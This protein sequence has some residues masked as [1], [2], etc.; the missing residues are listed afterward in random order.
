MTSFRSIPVAALA[1]SLL[2]SASGCTGYASTVRARA[3]SDFGCSESEITVDDI[4]G[5]TYRATGCGQTNE[6]TC[7]MGHGDVV[8][9]RDNAQTRGDAPS[10]AA[11]PAA[12]SSARPAATLGEPPS[13]A[14]GFTFGSGEDDARHACEQ[15]G[16]VYG[17]A[18][19]GSASCD[20]VASDIGSPARAGLTYC[21]GKLCTVS[22]R[23]DLGSG[24][25]LAR[26]LMRWKAA[27]VERYGDATGSQVNVPNGCEQDV[28]P[29]LLDRSGAIRFDWK[30]KSLQRISLSPQV[31]DAKKAWVTISYTAPEATRAK[32]PGL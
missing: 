2:L 12:P 23:I 22:L 16:H 30:W 27:L 4:P 6:Y 15:A 26:A 19:A 31:D 20:G 1:L 21:G 8:C 11:Q 5:S 14:G 9:V 28:T 25:N 3:A 10:P 13:G 17:A 18:S 32:A 29:C 24:E 7:M